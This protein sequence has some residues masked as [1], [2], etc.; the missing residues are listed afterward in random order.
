[1]ATPPDDPAS[2]PPLMQRLYDKPFLLLLAGILLMAVFYT[3]WGVHIASSA[4]STQD[5]HGAMRRGLIE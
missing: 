2:R 4:F 3:L 5:A 1:M